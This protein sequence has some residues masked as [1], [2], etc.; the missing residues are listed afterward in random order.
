MK[1]VKDYLKIHDE[2]VR[3]IDIMKTVIVE[4]E[5][6][7]DDA[8]ITSFQETHGINTR[9]LY[10]CA[11]FDEIRAYKIRLP[12]SLL[13]FCNKGDE[14]RLLFEIHN[15]INTGKMKLTRLL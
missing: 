12:V 9:Y 1:L 15:A 4:N 2:V 8:K 14:V 7:I 6:K 10:I 3:K 11:V 13:N 5:I